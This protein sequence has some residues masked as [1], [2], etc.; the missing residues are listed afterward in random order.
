MNKFEFGFAKE[1]ITPRFGAPL[2]GYFNPRPNTGAL[3]RLSL[4]AAVFRTSGRSYAAIVSYDL[5][6]ILAGFVQGV[7]KILTEKKSPL[8]GKVLYC[9][10]HTHTGPYTSEIF[11]ADYT[12]KD[13]MQQL[14]EKT[15]TALENACASLAPAELYTA[16]TECTTLAFNRRYVMKNGKI[17]TNPGK[18]NPD[19]VRPEGG[20][21]HAILMMEIRQNGFPALLITNISNHT[22]TIGGNLI[23]ADWPGR[24]EAEIQHEL[25]FALPVMSIIAPQG[26]INHFDVTSPVNQTGYEEAKRIG[27]AYAAAVLA[28][29]YRL[30]RQAD[31]SIKTAS[32]QVPA[33]YLKLTD[34]E[35]AAAK[36]VYAKYKNEVMEAGRDFTSE[37]IAKGTPFVMKYFAER[38][39]A[40]RENPIKKKRVETQL[41]ITFGKDLAIVSLPCEA[42]VELGMKIRKASK[43]PMTILAALGMGEI[44]YVGQPGNY[45]NGGYETSPS[46]GLADRTVGEAI[47]K[48]AIA[49]L[50]K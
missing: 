29:R 3:D 24:M 40:C 26:N 44:G 17:L 30:T 13:Y 39:I 7:E 41:V 10:T 16:R 12:D 20:V 19:I 9:A 14:R 18:L 2:C 1:D 4:K 25:G 49:L 6:Y 38:A 31:T 22:D 48:T 27:K 11:D 42:F 8:A 28:A 5:C 21:D 36:K 37:D 23:S 50:K 34:E 45:G 32:M 33:P 15:V 47:V 43:Y 46:R 35:Y